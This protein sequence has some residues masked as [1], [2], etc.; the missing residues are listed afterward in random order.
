MTMNDNFKTHRLTLF[1]SPET[2]T[3]MMGRLEKVF[4][5]RQVSDSASE[6]ARRIVMRDQTEVVFKPKPGN[7]SPYSLREPFA[8][9]EVRT[10][11]GYLKRSLAAMRQ[12]AQKANV[13]FIVDVVQVDEPA[14]PTELPRE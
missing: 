3:R 7:G 4:R 6:G 1:G 10:S 2:R 12:Y 14:K 11:D 13:P 8:E 5:R 9:M